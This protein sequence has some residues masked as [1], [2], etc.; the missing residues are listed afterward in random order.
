MTTHRCPA[1]L[2]AAPA[3]G[4]G[5]TT[6]ACALARLHA[7][8]GRRV[9]LFKCGPDF[10]D[11]HWLTLASDNPVHQLD[12]WMTGEADCA[13]RLHDAAAQADLIIIEG[14]MGLFDGEPSA[15]DLAQR[16]GLPVLAVIDASAMAGTFGALALG[17]QTF[18][19]GL[20]F[21]G[22]LANRVASPGHAAMLKDGLRD[23]A[24]WQGALMRSE[25]FTLPERHLG[26]VLAHELDDAMARLDA[27]ANELAAT[28]LG[29]MSM[30]DLQT[31]AVDFEAPDSTA[32]ACPDSVL[33]GKTIAIARDAA[34]CF[35]YVANIDCLQAMG[36]N[37][38]Y[39][40]PLK[41]SDVPPCDALW[42]PGGYPELHGEK[43]S[44]NTAMK[45]SIAAHVA[46]GKPVWAECGGMMA[47]FDELTALDGVTWPMWGVLP[48]KVTL[49]KRLAALGPQQLDI[50]GQVLR[51]HT[52]HYSTCATTMPAA[53]RTQAAAGRKL[54]GEGEALY[55]S[56]S[57]KS[58]RASYFHAWFASNP[59]AAANLFL[60]D[61]DA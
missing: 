28:P 29:Q 44:A 57:T 27:A 58:V 59:L 38:V 54:R 23:P 11:P 49:Q 16:F 48:G 21:A 1:I 2:I 4:Q 19:E 50:A 61:T 42:L 47:L 8:A 52:F 45:A 18:R 14:V 46:A 24:Q 9:L 31:F 22:V 51:G 53:T 3:S 60:K 13:Q 40:S 35:I 30:D 5:K 25:A 43:L 33:K 37:V 36:A 12:L 56:G 39:F 41:G 20:R 55:V 10:L 7:R 6:V 15:A 34:F 32:K 17:L 26:L